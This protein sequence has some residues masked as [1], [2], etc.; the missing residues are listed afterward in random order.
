MSCRQSV[1]YRG[2]VLVVYSRFTPQEIM[3]Q[4]PENQVGLVVAEEKGILETEGGREERGKGGYHGCCAVL[5][6]FRTN[7]PSNH[8]VHARSRSCLV[9]FQSRNL[10]QKK[11]YW[12]PT[13]SPRLSLSR[14]LTLSSSGFR[15]S[16]DLLISQSKVNRRLRRGPA[17][18]GALNDRTL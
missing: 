13:P 18:T 7:P 1:E 11:L 10:K 6:I 16:R 15:L 4:Y 5:C 8:P 17:R 9:L 3:N 2:T 12:V 14:S